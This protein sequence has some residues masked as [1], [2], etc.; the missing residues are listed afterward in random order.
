ML[1]FRKWLTAFPDA[2]N[3]NVLIFSFDNSH[4]YIPGSGRY[5][6]FVKD[7]EDELD[8]EKKQKESQKKTV[9]FTQI[10]EG[11][12]SNYDDI[13]YV[14]IVDSSYVSY[15]VNNIYGQLQVNQSGDDFYG[16][17][18]SNIPKIIHKQEQE[19]LKEF[20]DKD[21]VLFWHQALQNTTQRKTPWY[22]ISLTAPIKRCMRISK[23]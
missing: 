2:T 6:T 15:A 20:M 12:A 23:S 11:L 19:M 21:K 9:T 3:A 7:I 13:Y 8:A 18:F 1:S 22:Q 4:N 16:E 17:S 14:N 5:V 10:A